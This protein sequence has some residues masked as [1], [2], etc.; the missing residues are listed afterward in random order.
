MK[1]SF[2]MFGDIDLVSVFWNAVVSTSAEVLMFICAM[3]A[4]GVLFRLRRFKVRATADE[5]VNKLS[6]DFEDI[7]PKIPEETVDKV[8]I[9]A[10]P[11]DDFLSDNLH[12]TD[13]VSVGTQDAKPECPVN[14][15]ASSARE[16]EDASGGCF[17]LGLQR[18]EEQSATGAQVV[19]HIVKS[20]RAAP[21]GIRASSE[22]TSRLVCQL[23]PYISNHQ[24]ESIVGWKAAGGRCYTACPSEMLAV[25]PTSLRAAGLDSGWYSH[26]VC[27][28]GTLAQVKS[29]RRTLKK[30]GFLDRSDTSDFPL[31]GH[32]QTEHGL[33]VVIEGKMVRWSP[34]RAS[35]LRFGSPVTAGGCGDRKVCRLHLYGESVQG[36]L[37]TSDCAPGV[38]KILQW[39]NGDTWNSFEWRRVGQTTAFEQ[40]MTKTLRD[41]AQDSKV[42]AAA[43]SMLQCLSKQGLDL[44]PCATQQVLDFLGS[45][46]YFVRVC[47]DAPRAPAHAAGEDVGNELLSRISRKHPSVA[48]QH[49][50]V[51]GGGICC[52]E[53]T[54]IGG[55]KRSD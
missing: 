18:L 21:G 16:S 23:E 28:S 20:L 43:A 5:V 22:K 33:A 39:S 27:I 1:Q 8:S 26:E 48:L 47:F 25:V 30:Q 12:T 41:S 11:A 24:P 6:C 46:S 42:R 15:K 19:D 38:S 29:A 50:W 36:R 7:P 40:A 49:C 3:I 54:F 10:I 44:L 45:N 31:N 51:Q 34:Q 55:R 4:Y 13:K 17:E 53:S 2:Y 32:W 35:R 14:T 37:T 9:R 52:G